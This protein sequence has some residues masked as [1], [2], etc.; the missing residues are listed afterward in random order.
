MVASESCVNRTEARVV[1]LATLGRKK[2]AGVGDFL[3]PS[4]IF[5]IL[6]WR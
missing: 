5:R 3:N 1:L 6:Y 4:L 2:Y